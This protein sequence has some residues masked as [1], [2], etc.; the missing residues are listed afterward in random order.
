MKKQTAERSTILLK[1]HLPPHPQKKN[2]SEVLW[3]S[4][5][6]MQT[7]PNRKF[8]L[9]VLLDKFCLRH[10][11]ISLKRVTFFPNGICFEFLKGTV[12]EPVNCDGRTDCLVTQHNQKML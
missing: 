9:A 3:H 12:P 5:N 8:F 10:D 11:R 4:P 2:T 1:F 7:N 6:E